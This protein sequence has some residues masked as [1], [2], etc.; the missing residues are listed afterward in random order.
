ML[1]KNRIVAGIL[2]ACLML[3]SFSVMQAEDRGRDRDRKCEQKIEK[4]ENALRNAIRKHGEHS[5]QAEQ[6]RRKLEETR[7]RCHGGPGHDRDHDHD[8][9]HR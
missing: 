4:A 1:S 9:D 3:G 5:R 2:T 6:K 7:E 8:H